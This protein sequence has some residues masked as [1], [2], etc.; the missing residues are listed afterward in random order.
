MPLPEE[1]VFHD[2][3]YHINPKKAEAPVVS[4]ISLSCSIDYTVIWYDH[5]EDGYESD[6]TNATQATTEV[7][8]DGNAA[9]GCAP[10]VNPCT[11]AA[12]KLKAGSNIIIQNN[13]DIPRDLSQIRYDGGDKMQASFPIAVTRGAYPVGPGSLMAGA[14]EVVD[15]DSWGTDFVAPVGEDIGKHV[16]QSAFQYSALYFMAA[17]DNTT[18]TLPNSTTLKLHAGQGSMVRV[19]RGARLKSD[20]IIQV[21]FITGD[22]NSYYE[23][24]W[25]SLLDVNRW[26]NEYVS[27]VGDTV[28]RTRILMFNPSNSDLN[29]LVT[30]LA[31][32]GQ[33]VFKNTK[34]SAGRHALTPVIPTGSGAKLEAPESFLALSLTDTARRTEDGQRTGGQWYDWGFPVMPTNQLTPQVLIGWGYGC[35]NNNCFWQEERS[36]VWVTPVGS[37][38]LVC[39]LCSKT[40]S[41]MLL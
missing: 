29:V 35:T 5:Y 7:W 33:K 31:S 18:V 1:S 3:F 2:M 12:D 13:V 20:K 21:D 22:I 36:V 19:D 6:V 23:L 24:R 15:T 40:F 34:V 16:A 41:M 17:Y 25:Y 4:S 14:V 26:S 10:D 38:F 11:D 28:A 32:D 9:N 30:Y 39:V 37:P 8:G 27:P